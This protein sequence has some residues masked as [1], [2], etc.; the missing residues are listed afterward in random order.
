MSVTEAFLPRAG[1]KSCHDGQ[2]RSPATQNSMKATESFPA[3]PRGLTAVAFGWGFSAVLALPLLAYLRMSAE[4]GDPGS[5][6]LFMKVTRVY[7][8]VIAMAVGVFSGI[9][10]IRRPVT[11]SFFALAPFIGLFL[12]TDTQAQGIACSGTA[13]LL[14]CVAAYLAFR[15]RKGPMPTGSKTMAAALVIQGV[16]I[17]ILP[18]FYYKKS[19]DID[20]GLGIEWKDGIRSPG[21]MHA[22]REARDDHV[23]GVFRL[24][25]LDG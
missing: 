17:A 25:E 20:G 2:A 21:E 3:F 13:L 10:A 15:L 12:L 8:L 18:G 24:Y 22:A 6:D 14:G 16:V 7:F 9:K 1:G 11:V 4:R 23:N 5:L 19:C